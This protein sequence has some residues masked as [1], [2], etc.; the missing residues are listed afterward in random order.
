MVTP[1]GKQYQH[2]IANLFGNYKAKK[3]QYFFFISVFIVQHRWL[4]ARESKKKKKSQ[5]Q[6]AK[7]SKYNINK[8]S[9]IFAQAYII[10][11]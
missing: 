2:F 6:K 1:N 4:K 8:S 10:S 3:K 5:Q 11:G 7:Q 9:V